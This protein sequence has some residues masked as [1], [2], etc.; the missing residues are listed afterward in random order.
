[1]VVRNASHRNGLD[2]IIDQ[3]FPNLNF[4]LSKSVHGSAPRAI[5]HFF[6]TKSQRKIRG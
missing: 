1:M 4:Y 3:T 5:G 6:I 2:R